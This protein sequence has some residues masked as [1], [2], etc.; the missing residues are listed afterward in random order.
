MLLPHLLSWNG[1][2]HRLLSAFQFASF[3][4]L[5][6]AIQ[7]TAFAFDDNAPIWPALKHNFFGNTPIHEDASELLTLEAPKRAED[8]AIVPVTIKSLIPQTASRHITQLHLFIDNN[9]MPHAASFTLS[10]SLQ[11][12][13]LAT[14]VRV[15]SYTHM[16]VVAEMNDGSLHMVKTFVKA[17][18]GCS[19][20]AG[21]DQAAALERLGKMQIRMRPVTLG[22]ATPVQV[23]VSHPNNSGLQM[24]QVTRGYIPAHYV[25]TMSV[26]FNDEPLITMQAGISLSEDPSLRF[27]FTPTK[28]GTLSTQVTDSKEQ[29]FYQQ[30][31]L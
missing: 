22:E 7:P 16:R 26:A 1:N 30:K 23:I 10:P 4:L 5:L 9:P 8:A 3:F 14:R 12:V 28:A 25:K 11:Q 31:S 27:V 21:K 29:Q 15:D 6:I 20:P 13:D 17:S 2:N 24:D 19:A 18:G